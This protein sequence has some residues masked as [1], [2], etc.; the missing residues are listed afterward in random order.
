M[1]RIFCALFAG[2]ALAS[3]RP[4]TAAAQAAPA[5]DALLGLWAYEG[6]FGPA[7]RGALTLVRRGT[8]WQ[9]MIGGRTAAGTSEGGELFFRFGEQGGFRGRLVDG[10]RRLEGF[11]LQPSGASETRPNPGGSGQRFATPVTLAALGRG[12][13]R[14]NVVPLDDR[15]RLYLSIFRDGRGVLTAAFRNPELNFTGGAS[16]F[17]VLRE[18]DRI[19]FNLRYD[20]GELNHEAR[21]LARPERLELRWRGF[22]R[23][24]VLRRIRPALATGFH[25]APPGRRPYVYRAPPATG[26]G[27]RTAAASAGGIDEAALTQIVRD[28]AQS[29]PTTR[30]PKLIHSLLVAHRGR[31]MLEEYF[32]GYDRDTPHDIRSAG[33]TFSSVLLGTVMAETGLSPDSRVAPLLAAGAPFANPD[34]RKDAITL[35]H[36][37]THSAGLA[38]NDNDDASPGN[39]GTMQGQREQPDWWRYTLDLP[40][41]HDP[42]TRYAYCSAN[43]NLVGGALTRATR[44]WLPRL[45]ERMLAR[46]LQFGRWHWNLMPNGEGYLGGGAFLRPR[47]LLKIGQM[48]L[49]GGMWNG[50]RIVPAEWVARSTAPR[51][52]ISPATTGYSEEEFGEYYGRGVDGLAWHLGAFTVNG[53]QVQI[54]SAT[55]NGGQILL[56]IPE[57]RLAVVF[58]GG[59]YMQGGIWGRWGELIVANRIIPATRR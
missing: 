57:Y 52:E 49:D 20:G 6:D 1:L 21:L 4:A 8:G 58:T 18:G 30:P 5:D 22:T 38:C 19:R 56:V 35:A 46:P 37:M 28:I 51:M 10:G 39:E 40:M 33:K 17:L 11:W 50:R 44:T 2:L 3:L 59:N 14:G 47:D 54:Y 23:P 9:G 36:L 12:R 25:P 55:G 27:W 26:D 15:F 53:R 45:F 32:F 13:W 16:R 34:P 42:G 41:A 29:D 24:L 7:L 31:L 48:Y 43:T